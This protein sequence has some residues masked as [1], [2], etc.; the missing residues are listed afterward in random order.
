MMLITAISGQKLRI[1]KIIGIFLFLVILVNIDRE[2]LI[3][4]LQKAN[5]LLVAASFPLL[6][7]M[8]LVKT[9]RWHWLAVR[10]GKARCTFY[11]S[12]KISLIG[13]F[14][15]QITPG[16]IGEFGKVA[17]LKRAGTNTYDAIVLIII[18]RTLDVII[19]GIFAIIG[20]GI[21]FGIGWFYLAFAAALLSL[22][23]IQHFLPRTITFLFGGTL[24]Q[25][26]GWTV[27]S[28]FI[29]FLWAVMLAR[30]LGISVDPFILIAAFTVAGI[31]SLIP[32]APSG[33]GTRDAVLITLLQPYGVPPEQ[34]VALA[35]LMFLSLIAS[36]ILGG[37][38]FMREK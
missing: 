9:L 5:V 31:I 8:Y 34:A 26:I 28:W 27:V 24:L 2:A 22:F 36:T 21:L 17:Y 18:D 1:L 15:G 6:F 7:C 30:S 3:T 37:W 35:M 20:I 19:I 16:K 12:W 4:N 11:D 13:L 32:I 23:M 25:P 14:L 10:G 38:Y 33:L 29:Y